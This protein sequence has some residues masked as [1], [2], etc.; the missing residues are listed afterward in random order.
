MRISD[1]SSDVCSSDL[2]GDRVLEE[3]VELTGGRVQRADGTGAGFVALGRVHGAVGADPVDPQVLAVGLRGVDQHPL[4][5]LHAVQLGAFVVLALLVA[6][7]RANRELRF[8]SEEH[9]S[10]LQSLMRTSYAVFC[11]KKKTK[12]TPNT[13]RS[14]R[15]NT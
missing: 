2:L 7:R 13:F 11:L 6:A 15:S 1:W 5:V 10:E 4:A 9:T 3:A 8:R 14:N 12:N